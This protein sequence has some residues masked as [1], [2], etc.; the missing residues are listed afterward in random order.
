MAELMKESTPVIDFRRPEE[1]A[2]VHEVQAQ[3]CR[4][5]N[6]QGELNLQARLDNDLRDSHLVTGADGNVVAITFGPVDKPSAELTLDC[7]KRT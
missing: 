3:I 7:G 5:S 1:L 2:V 4:S 6:P